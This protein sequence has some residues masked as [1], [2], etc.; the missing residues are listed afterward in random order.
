[1]LFRHC[2][3][4]DPVNL[5]AGTLSYVVVLHFVRVQ[6]RRNE[7]DSRSYMRNCYFRYA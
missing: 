3:A 6:R 5:G 4:F 1:M 7:F 2:V